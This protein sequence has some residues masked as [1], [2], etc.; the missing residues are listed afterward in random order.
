MSGEESIQHFLVGG[1]IFL[2]ENDIVY[3]Q[4]LVLGR[5]ILHKA[6]QAPLHL[7]LGGAVLLIVQE[8]C[9]LLPFAVAAHQY[10]GGD[11]SADFG[12]LA[13]IA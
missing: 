13:Y 1:G 12:V 8:K 10:F 4:V 6:F 3:S 9:Q 5:K 11:V 7:H 2:V